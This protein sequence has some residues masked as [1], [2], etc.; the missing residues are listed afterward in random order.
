MSFLGRP[1]RL[2][3][4][5]RGG[6]VAGQGGGAGGCAG[7]GGRRGR[8][9]GGGDGQGDDVGQ[10][11]GQDLGQGV[12][13]ELVGSVQVRGGAGVAGGSLRWCGGLGAGGEDAFDGA[14]GRV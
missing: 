14:V 13:E 8:V 9:G 12:G 1:G 4:W 11:I 6:G 7:R 5:S 10:D 2:A 3:C